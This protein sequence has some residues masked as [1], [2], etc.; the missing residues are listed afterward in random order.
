MCD[1]VEDDQPAVDDSV[2]NLLEHPRWTGRVLG[3]GDRD[4]RYRD[5]TQAVADVEGPQGTARCDVSLVG[6]VAEGV[7]QGRG[8]STATDALGQEAGVSRSISANVCWAMRNAV[9]AA[10]T[11]Q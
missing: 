6:G 3:A 8:A 10:G 1:V 7:Q 9:L 2:G 5:L 11:P 4:H